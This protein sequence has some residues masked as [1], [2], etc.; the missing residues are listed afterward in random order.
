[1]QTYA[2]KAYFLERVFSD[3]FLSSAILYLSRD[4][5]FKT[6]NVSKKNN[7]YPKIA[8][9]NLANIDF[10]DK[11]IGIASFSNQNGQVD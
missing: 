8:S 9:K 4:C 11:V 10:F 6:N 1:M 2:F 3:I 5:F 7:F